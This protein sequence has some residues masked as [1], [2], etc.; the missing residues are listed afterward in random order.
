MCL[1]LFYCVLSDFRQYISINFIFAFAHSRDNCPC[2]DRE[3]ADDLYQAQRVLKQQER[4]D[5]L[6]EYRNSYHFGT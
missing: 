5:E 1:T 2:I 3:S 4:D 6:N